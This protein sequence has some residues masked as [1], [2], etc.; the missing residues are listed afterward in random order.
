MPSSE[1]DCCGGTYNWFWTEAFDKFGFN[2]GDGQVETWN[3]ES[4]L[5]EA[6]YDVTVT[7]WGMHNTVI[8]S[9][10]GRHRVHSTR[11][12]ARVSTG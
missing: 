4:V 2:D 3:V 6:G 10:N 9:I 7:G 1:C 8:T 11:R 5:T 12:S